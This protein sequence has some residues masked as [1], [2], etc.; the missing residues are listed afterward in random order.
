MHFK[1]GKSEGKCGGNNEKAPIFVWTFLL[2]DINM[3]YICLYI[4]CI[5]RRNGIE[6]YI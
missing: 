2:H 4:I 1:N 6:L 3:S 5:S